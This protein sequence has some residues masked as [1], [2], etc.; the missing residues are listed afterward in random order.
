MGLGAV[1][2]IAAGAGIAELSSHISSNKDFISWMSTV[3]E[4]VAGYAVF[5]PLHAKDNQDIY[6]NN[7]GEFMWCGFFK[8]Q[9]K[10]AGSLVLID[11]AYLTG[12]PFIAK[13]ILETGVNPAHASLYADAI[14][15]P[16]LMAAAFPL[17]KITGNLRNG[18]EEKVK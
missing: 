1:A 15:Y 17:A 5:L 7:E 13:E 6:R 10:L 3:S 8:D 9:A 4:Y 2:G 16:V 18:L 12:R 14:S 11:I